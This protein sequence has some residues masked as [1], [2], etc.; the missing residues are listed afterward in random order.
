MR[1][2]ESSINMASARQY[3]QAGSRTGMSGARGSFEEARG[4]AK[5]RMGDLPGGDYA[6]GRDGYS[7]TSGMDKEDGGT[8]D[9]GSYGYSKTLDRLFGGIRASADRETSAASEFQNLLLSLLLSRFGG[10]MMGGGSMQQILTYQEYEYTEFHADGVARTDDGREI[11]FNVDISM[12]RSYMEYMNVYVPSVESAL[13]DPLVVNVGSGIADV[14]DQRFLFDIDA[15]GEEDEIPMLGR[16]SGFLALDKNE[17]GKINDGSELF[18]TKSG[19]GF[20]DLKEYDSDGNGW[21]DEND[22]VF[23]KL[24]VWCKNDDG[25]DILMDLKEADIGAIYLGSQSTEFTMNGYDAATDGVLRSTGLFLRE[26]GSVG[27]VQHVDVAVGSASDAEDSAMSEGQAGTI[28]VLSISGVDTGVKS[29]E[30]ASRSQS[31]RREALSKKRA[32]ERQK[33]EELQ[34]KREE[35]LEE[36]TELEEARMERYSEKQARAERLAKK[37]E[38]G[39]RNMEKYFRE[40]FERAEQEREFLEEDPIDRLFEDTEIYSFI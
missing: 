22:E 20:A 10:A 11:S 13:C 37:Y 35:R 14:R 18:G 15:D 8:I 1:I 7:R 24:K 27:T 39:R 34:K 21:I 9:T 33:A 23:G 5:S 32:A 19:N 36:K 2:T 30:Q 4:N 3:R 25:E 29:S 12:S 38:E 31:A 40:R 16:G 26:S 17:D 28:Q 6:D